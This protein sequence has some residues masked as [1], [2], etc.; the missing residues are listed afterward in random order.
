MPKNTL[1]IRLTEASVFLRTSDNNAR[2]PNPNDRSDSR[3]SMLRGLLTLNIVKPI[4]VTSIDV[5]LQAKTTTC[6]PE[7]TGLSAI[8]V[9]ETHEVFS[10]S[11][12]FFRAGPAPRRPTSMGPGVDPRHDVDPPS[13]PET[14][15]IDDFQQPRSSVPP[16]GSVQTRRISTTMARMSK[17]RPSRRIHLCLPLHITP[18]R[19][20]PQVISRALIQIP[21]MHLKISATRWAYRQRMSVGDRSPTASSFS[22]FDS[23]LS[24]RP[25]SVQTLPEVDE[26][27]R[28]AAPESIVSGSSS[29]SHTR[30]LHA[31]FSLSS[32]SSA[33]MDVVHPPK[34]HSSK[35]RSDSEFRG[36]TREKTVRD[37]IGPSHQRPALNNVA[38]PK[39]SDDGTYTFPISFAI[40]PDA[41]P[42]M[43][44]PCGNVVWRLKANVHRPGTFAA[45]MHAV[46]QVLVIAAPMEDDT[47]EL[48]PIVVERH[49]EQQLQYLISISGRSFP[50]GGVVPITLTMMPI[51]K[52]KIHRV[53]IVLEE[54]IEYHSQMKYVAQSDPI[55]R[56]EL[57]S[58]KYD[59]DKRREPILPLE[60]NDVEALKNS[61]LLALTVP[62]DDLSQLAAEW[63]GPGPWTFHQELQLPP[64]CSTLHFTNKNKWSNMF[65]THL[66]KCIMRVERGDDAAIDPN[67]GKRKL[68]DIV[69]QTPVHILSCRCN[70]E[71]M[72]LPR[73]CASFD[74]DPDDDVAPSCPCERL[75]RA[76]LERAPVIT[77]NSTDSASAAETSPVHAPIPSLRPADTL[78]A[79]NTR[80]EH[81]VSG[82]ENELG[83]APPAYDT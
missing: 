54:K 74:D 46:R 36:R 43:E 63:M 66:I 15:R 32:V 64:S 78:F 26:T 42:S 31:H 44:C 58:V 17:C 13:R 22:E 30:G 11:I 73:Y 53:S 23:S 38:A 5:E 47:E 25:S 37:D 33:L 52:V 3:P 50:I 35:E 40:P 34:A 1:T 48:E 67:T 28:D 51:S 80:F 21:P 59:D 12:V 20:N 71:W 60:S 18:V 61:P 14:P 8:D 79:R 69:V 9:Q 68:Y 83:E 55:V 77:R 65:V 72:S 16:V 49:W 29:P 76:G 7:G 4:K 10:E 6:W 41:P 19:Y 70:P 45:R 39:S 82:Q 75:R 24:R 2:G 62:E 81:L 27:R 57:L 56:I